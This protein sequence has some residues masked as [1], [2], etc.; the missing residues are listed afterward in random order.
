[1]S[2]QTFL[3]KYTEDRVSDMLYTYPS[4]HIKQLQCMELS[5]EV[6]NTTI[7]GLLFEVN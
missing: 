6:N 5:F 4:S 2:L 7:I 1:M 3:E